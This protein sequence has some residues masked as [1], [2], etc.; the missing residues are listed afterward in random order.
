MRQ[1]SRFVL[2]AI[3]C[4]LVWSC[5][6]PD[7]SSSIIQKFREYRVVVE[8]TPE[9]S[10]LYFSHQRVAGWL[11]VLLF[12]E[13]YPTLDSFMLIEGDFLY[14]KKIDVVHEYIVEKIARNRYM[15]TIFYSGD[16]E[17]GLRKIEI[18]YVVERGELAIDLFGFY[19][20][21]QGDVPAEYVES[22]KYLNAAD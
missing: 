10:V 2:T 22:F 11:G 9:E 15:L 4:G 6:E 12:E 16:E 3:V 19:G 1:P 5:A 20:S 18:E 13:P 14:A 8:V 17:E 7:Y 21:S